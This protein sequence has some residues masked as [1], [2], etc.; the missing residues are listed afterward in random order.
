MNPLDLVKLT[1]LMKLTSGRPKIAVGLIDGPVAIDHPDLSGANIRGI[2]DT[3]SGACAGA[4]SAA[5]KHGTFVARI[6]CGKP[7][8]VSPS[9]CRHCS[10]LVRPV[11]AGTAE[12]D[13]KE[14]SATSAGLAAAIIDC[15][16]GG[17]HIINLSAATIQPS[18]SGSRELGESLNY[19]ARRGV[20]IVAAAGNQGTVGG[21]MITRHS[22]VIPVVACDHRG[23]PLGL[24][25]LSS[26]TGKRGI[27]APGRSVTDLSMDG[28]PVILEGTSVSVPFVSGTI[29]LLWSIFPRASAAL[30]RSAVLQ[31]GI[32]RRSSVLPPLLDASAALAVVASA[33]SGR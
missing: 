22:W 10:L 6:L 19:A 17:A 21:S 5:C 23:R 12:A 20:I 28:R 26:S 18:S 27:M 4:N 24:S 15:V 25:N 33:N 11:F 29:A 16:D 13:G 30:L 3:L 7:S 32:T 1:S 14:P 8:V 2:P 31:L 9:I